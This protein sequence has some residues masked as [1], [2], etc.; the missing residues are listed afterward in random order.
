MKNCKKCD[1]EFMP[2]KGL[3]N[4]CSIECRNSRTFNNESR[5][6]KRKSNSNQIPWNKGLKSTWIRTKCF[7]C[8][9]D[10]EHPKCKPKKYHSEC[11]LKSSGGYRKGSGVGKKGYYEGYWCD[12]SWELAWVIYH[13][14]NN[15][16]FERNKI[17]F[18][19]EYKNKKRKYFPDFIVQGVYYEIKGRKNFDEL[20]K[21][22]KEK[23]NQ[24][25]EKLIVLYYEQIK[26]YL[27]YVISKYGDDYIRLYNN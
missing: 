18:V 6:K 23:I 16:S 4:F 17:G 22:D 1:C 24:F 25:K 26:P 11:W 12:S 8:G 10:I 9:N 2:A 15:I 3:I 14:E 27:D 5:D 7:F 21:I 20:S 13:L 19:Y